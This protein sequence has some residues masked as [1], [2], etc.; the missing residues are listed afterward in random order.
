MDYRFLE[1]DEKEYADFVD[2][3][4]QHNFFQ[5]IRMGN[6]FKLEKLERYY[7]GVKQ[8]NKIVAATL[9]V[10]NSPLFL[11]S[12]TFDCPKGP[13]LDYN[14]FELVAFFTSELKKFVKQK[15]GFRVVIDPYVINVS[16]DCDGKE[17]SGINNRSIVNGLESN[18]YKKL[19]GGVQVKWI[20]C[21]DTLKKSIEELTKEMN[22]NTRNYINQ[23]IN[24]YKV[25]C[26]ELAYS[27]LNEFK[28]ITESTC[29]RKGFGDRS[30]K[31]YQNMFN[32]FGKQV[33]FIIA[34][35]YPKECIV[36]LKNEIEELNLKISKLSSSVKNNKKIR[37]YKTDID[38]N[39]KKINELNNIFNESGEKIAISGAMF[40][41]YG[42]EVVYL[43]SGSHEEYMHYHGQY[44]IQYE[45]IKYACT[46]NYE[47]YNFYG[48]SDN[49]NPKDENY[50][51]YKFKKSFGGYVEELI[52]SFELETT[53]LYK[54]YSL[55]R[56]LKRRK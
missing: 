35:L 4:L 30:L 41:I 12:K 26:E 23:A 39:S 29:Q 13:I 10:N 17:I 3:N 28:H 7:I 25:R 53:V 15:G 27:R 6:R 8:N 5:T 22:S 50:G 48:I 9:I 19:K 40:I 46:N 47:R 44:L 33:K 36:V 42:R 14:N 37:Q 24:K 45:M 34:Y 38:N 51:I 18:G 54:M 31:Y 21:L 20:Y 11:G 1:I 49:F 56:H 32:C 2:N 55:I 16:R 43:F 52:G